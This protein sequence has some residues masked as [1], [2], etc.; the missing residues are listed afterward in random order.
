MKQQVMQGCRVAVT[1]ALAASLS[2]AQ[3]LA[4]FGEGAHAQSGAAS[5]VRAVQPV[6]MIGEQPTISSERVNGFEHPSIGFSKTSLELMQTMLREG[7]DPW[8]S[9][10]EEFAQ[11]P[12]AAIDYQTRNSDPSDPTRP[13]YDDM[14]GDAQAREGKVDGDAAWCQAVMY[15]AT[16]K[17]EYRQNC[18]DILRKWSQVRQ[19]TAAF[20]DSHISTS[21]AVYP[22]VRA[23]ELMRYTSSP[24][25]ELVWTQQ[26]TDAFTA[27]L[28]SMRDL[29]GFY[30]V[31]TRHMNQQ[32]IANR[33]YLAIAIF[34]NNDAYYREAVEWTLANKSYV[35][36]SGG[37]YGRNGSLYIQV[38]NVD[39]NAYSGEALTS[40]YQV[41]EMGRDQFHPKDGLDAIASNLQAM[42]LQG[43]RVND[44]PASDTFGEVDENGVTPFE[45]MD[46]RLLKGYNQLSKYNLGY[47]INWTPIIADE[48]GEAVLPTYSDNGV[49]ALDEDGNPTV[50]LYIEPSENG[51]GGMLYNG[52]LLAHYLYGD[53]SIDW[54]SEDTRYIKEAFDRSGSS[55]GAEAVLVGGV[56]AMKGEQVGQPEE[57]ATSPYAD[58]QAAYDRNQFFDYLGRSSSVSTNTFADDDGPRSVLYDVKGSGQYTWYKMTFDTPVDHITARMASKANGAA[59]GTLVDVVVLDDVGGLDE[60]NVTSADIDAGKTIATIVMP[61]TGSWTDYVTVSQPLQVMDKDTGEP[62]TE[63][64]T[65]PAGEHIIA[66]R[67]YDNYGNSLKYQIAADWFTFSR[68]YASQQN[69]AVDADA[70]GSSAMPGAEGVSVS[71]GGSIAFDD[72]NFDNGLGAAILDYTSTSDGTLELRIDGKTVA[73]YPLGDTQGARRTVTVC[74]SGDVDRMAATGRHDVELV[75]AGEKPMTLYSYANEQVPYVQAALDTSFEFEDHALVDERRGSRVQ[76][77]AGDEPGYLELDDGGYAIV[78]SPDL[79]SGPISMRVKASAPV[80]LELMYDSNSAEPYHTVYI[81]STDGAWQDVAFDLSGVTY[82]ASVLYM[83][84]RSLVGEDAVVQ[85]DSKQNSPANMPPTFGAAGRVST[86]SDG[87]ASWDLKVADAEGDPVSCELV[88]PVPGVTLEGSHLQVAASQEGARTAYVQIDDGHTIVVKRFDITAAGDVEARMAA[89]QESVGDVAQ[90]TPATGQVYTEALNGLQQACAGAD[91]TDVQNAL[92]RLVSAVAG[93]EKMNAFLAD[94]TFDYLSVCDLSSSSRDAK[95]TRAQLANLV[96]GDADTCSDFRKGATD[97]SGKGGTFTLDMGEGFGLSVDS[98]SLSA[99]T[100]WGHGGKS[101]RFKGVYVEGSDDGKTWTKITDEVSDGVN[102]AVLENKVPERTFRYIRFASRNSWYGNLGEMRINGSRVAVSA[103]AGNE[104]ESVRISSSASDAGK[105]RVGDIVTL[106]ATMAKPVA[107]AAVRVNGA[108]LDTQVN[109]R[110][111]TASYK[112]ETGAAPGDVVFSIVADGVAAYV[113]T[114]GSSVTVLPTQR[115]SEVAQA[116][117]TIADPTLGGKTLV[118]PQVPGFA[119]ELARVDD[120]GDG[121]LSADGTWTAHDEAAEVAVTLRVTSKADASDTAETGVLKVKLPARAN[122]DKLLESL[123]LLG[124]F[125]AKEFE[126]IDGVVASARTVAQDANASE[127]QIATAHLALVEALHGLNKYVPDHEMLRQVVQASQAV[128]DALDASYADGNDKDTFKAAH[129]GACEVLDRPMAS[130]EEIQ[131]G[132]VTLKKATEAI[133]DDLLDSSELKA[134]IAA[135]EPIADELDGYTASSAQTFQD[136]LSQAQQL[137]GHPGSQDAIDAAARDLRA[138]FEALECGVDKQAVLTAVEHAEGFLQGE[139]T[140]ESLAALEQAIEAARAVASDDDAAYEEGTAAVRALYDAVA[141]LEAAEDDSRPGQDPDPETPGDGGASGN[142][143]D[144]SSG[145]ARRED[146][147]ASA[148][149]KL[150]STGDARMQVLPGVGACLAAAGAIFTRAAHIRRKRR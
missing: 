85:L 1:A 66:F 53:A 70:F 57:G 86:V 121:A 65:I 133:A 112:V 100:G 34:E 97:S 80:A 145:G 96:D 132:Y 84:A 126:S 10:L 114:E 108:E 37:V 21:E 113:T 93:L 89:Y 110:T 124:D 59:R 79:M 78:N 75:Y 17:V 22:M 11:K 38:R 115:A 125:N 2:L 102:E 147:G 32:S 90:Y 6:S 56:E 129:E 68:H 43:T 76:A 92:E 54:A 136:A 13:L 50:P 140:T 138:A 95:G 40:H 87:S 137:Q 52:T 98:F 149:D 16:G 122:R 51:R 143:G 36:E 62:T 88:V 139:Y 67:Y 99:R 128:Y 107:N 109:G 72:M 7:Y 130:A 118:M 18:M 142:G 49:A 25:E 117:T 20:T 146:G 60:T 123:D 119:V 48:K 5:S 73:S 104:F 45:F 35:T 77:A 111:V 144:A 42:Q 12:N 3:P 27:F 134:T 71:N 28:E 61:D 31:N 8:V 82:N 103:E 46:N 83:R 116:I 81:P 30:H 69:R 135:Y 64:A 19:K 29:K 55:L 131:Q 58:K 106:T 63:V 141:H 91:K 74:A 41:A 148:A 9:A 4:A 15:V 44:D 105:A 94:G 39:V 26:D 127:L 150:P 33:L 120:D 23:A 101:N 47:D 14:S 24:T